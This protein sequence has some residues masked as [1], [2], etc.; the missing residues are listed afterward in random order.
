MIAK[1]DGPG[2]VDLPRIF[3]KISPPRICNFL[4]IFVYFSYFFDLKL[5]VDKRGAPKAPPPI[6]LSIL[7]QKNE[8]YAKTCKNM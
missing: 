7:D 4:H 5:I 6:T 1:V 8:K 3:W 2:Q